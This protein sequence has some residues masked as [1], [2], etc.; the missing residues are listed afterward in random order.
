MALSLVC[1]NV[2]R[3]KHLDTV[4]PFLEEQQPD[5]T[6]VQE[7]SDRDIAAYEE[8]VGPLI[9]Y[10]P[11]ARRADEGC[12]YGVGTFSR[13]PVRAQRVSYYRGAEDRVPD[14]DMSSLEKKHANENAAFIYADVEKEGTIYRVGTTHFTW[15]PNGQPDDYQRADLAKLLS[16]LAEAGE[17][18]FCGDFNAPRGGEI[19]SE[20]AGRYKDN[21]PL[22]YTWSLDLAIHRHGGGKIEKDAHEAGFSGFM[23]DGLFTTPG[24]HANTVALVNGVSD[25]SAIVATIEK[26]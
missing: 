3:S 7:L 22:K 15:T 2:E 6:C 9:A 16:I 12:V 4:F 23:V 21:I 25:H 24:Y 1:L 8:R 19:F 11:M 20:L 18:V 5:I 13:Q 26:A 17:M 14:F 10:V